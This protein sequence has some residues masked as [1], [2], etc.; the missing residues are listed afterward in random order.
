MSE[1]STSELRPAH[2]MH[3]CIYTHTNVFN[4]NK[5]SM[6]ILIDQILLHRNR[7][8]VVCFYVFILNYFKFFL[9]ICLL[10]LVC[11]VVY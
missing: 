3:A 5:N 2:F 8:V 4:F 11:N 7:Q 9:F 10:F 6:T 1:R